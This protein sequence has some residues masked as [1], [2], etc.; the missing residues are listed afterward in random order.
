MGFINNKNIQA[1]I[2]VGKNETKCIEK[3]LEFLPNNPIV[4]YANE[5]D[6]SDNFS[7]PPSRGILIKEAN[8]KPNVDLIIQSIS[9][10]TGQIVLTS[11]NQKDVPKKLFN[12][13][14]LKR[15]T[16]SDE[17]LKGIAPRSNPPVDYDLD[18]FKLLFQFCKSSDR[19]E[20]LKQLNLNLL[21]HQK[22]LFVTWLSNNYF[23]ELLAYSFDGRLSGRVN[24]PKKSQKSEMPSICRKLKLRFEE[25]HLLDKLLEDDDFV[26]YA[27]TKL[28]N[29]QCRLLGLGEKRVRKEKKKKENI[30]TL[31]RWL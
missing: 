8:Y 1:M 2:V 12:M 11:S 16:G 23:N 6:I 14:K 31:D 29:R 28:D 17:S 4:V 7:I 20:V 24:M 10:Y 15:A 27:K 30:T 26:K 19:E 21:P 13:L 3:A 5:Y 18:I 22:S 9:E 25:Q